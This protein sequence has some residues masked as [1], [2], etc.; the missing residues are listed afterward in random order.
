MGSP[1]A[2][3]EASTLPPSSTHAS[4]TLVEPMTHQPP[5]FP[6]PQLSHTEPAV[7]MQYHHA[8]TKPRWCSLVAPMTAADSIVT[9]LIT[10]PG[11]INGHHCAIPMLLDSG[12]S[13]NFVDKQFVEQVGLEQVTLPHPIQVTTANGQAMICDKLIA[14][15]VV[16]VD[17]HTGAH[18][19]VVIPQLDKFQV[20]LGRAFLKRSHANVCHA[21]DKVTWSNRHPTRAEAVTTANPWAVLAD[22][23]IEPDDTSLDEPSEHDCTTANSVAKQST[24]RTVRTSKVNVTKHTVRRNDHSI[25]D[26]SVT[27]C[28]SIDHSSTHTVPSTSHTDEPIAKPASQPVQPPSQHELTQ[29][30]LQALERIMASRCIRHQNEAT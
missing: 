2:L 9:S 7:A 19:L 29:A 21:T 10:L 24:C 22:R 3:I 17:G 23:T 25:S 27:P 12:A 15:A 30:H 6:P 1:N 11:T 26:H 4:S 18:D 28:N 13:C 16:A 5:N 20:V 8:S 14:G